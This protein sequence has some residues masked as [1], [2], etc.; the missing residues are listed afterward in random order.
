[1]GLTK[2]LAEIEE[3]FDLYGQRMGEWESF[4]KGVEYEAF[5]VQRKKA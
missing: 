5:L 2:Y 1:M 3:D 4:E